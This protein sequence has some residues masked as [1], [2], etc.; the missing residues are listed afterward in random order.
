MVQNRIANS[1]KKNHFNF[2]LQWLNQKEHDVGRGRIR[3]LLRNVRIVTSNWALVT[4][5]D[6][7]AWEYLGSKDAFLRAAKEILLSLRRYRF[8]PLMT[9][10][11]PTMLRQWVPVS[12]PDGKFSRHWPPID[13][14]Y[15]DVQAVYELDGSIERIWECECGKWFCRRFS[16]QK[17]CSSKCRE[18]ANK[19]TP[20]WKE[21][22]RRKAREYY[23]LHRNKKTR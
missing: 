5:E 8:S 7:G 13:R 2:L 19:S 11:G 14:K 23:W 6:G 9:P 22:R 18:K 21:Y 1:S 4:D 10:F 20:A 16:H 3:S 17:F 12:G 15:D